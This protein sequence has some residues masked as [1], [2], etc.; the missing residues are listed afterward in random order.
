M[1]FTKVGSKGEIWI[2]D[3]DLTKLIGKKNEKRGLLYE[4]NADR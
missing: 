2:I 4:R 3:N 1:R